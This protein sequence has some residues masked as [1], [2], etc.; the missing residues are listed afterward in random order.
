MKREILSTIETG[1]DGLCSESC[2]FFF[3][4]VLGWPCCDIQRGAIKRLSR[5]GD[6][7]F[8]GV[9]CQQCL[10]AEKKAGE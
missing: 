7:Y 8:Y 10:D 5:S 4:E 1:K 9:R 3:R 2:Q 6:G